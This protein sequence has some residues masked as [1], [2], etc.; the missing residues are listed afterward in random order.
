MKLLLALT[1]VLLGLGSFAQNYNASWKKV[2]DL[3][4][5]GL[6]KSALAE[7]RKIYDQAKAGKND[8]Q[9]VKALVY[10]S[11]LQEDNRE[12]NLEFSTQELEKEIA[13]SKEPV[14][15]VL[16]SLLAGYYLRYYNQNRWKLFN[17][18]A[19]VNFIK[20]D[21]STWSAED[22]HKKISELFLLSVENDKILKQTRIENFDP[23]IIKGNVRH[24]R[25]TLYDLLVH[26]AIGYFENDERDIK[27]PAYAFQLDNANAFDPA[28]EF[29]K[30]R[31]ASR[32]SLALQLKALQLYQNLLEFHL[33]DANPSALI[34][35]DINRLDFV[36]RN[37]VH[38]YKDSLYYQSLE[39]ITQKY[40]D[41]PAAAMAW[42]LM[43]AYLE[44]KASAYR[45]YSDST[46][47][48]SRVKA[49]T[50]V[51][52]ILKQKDSSEGRTLAANLLN[53]INRKDLRFSIEKVNLPGQPLRSL[54]KYRNLNNVHLRIVRATDALKKE[55]EVQRMEE[56]WKLAIAASPLKS[57]QQ[58]LPDPQDMQEHGAE[59]KID[60]LDK[61]EYILLA[62]AEKDF[63]KKNSLVGARMFYVSTIS[64]VNSGGDYFV[65]NRDNGQPLANAAIQVW[66]QKYDYSSYRYVKQKEKLYNANDKGYF[67]LENKRDRGVNGLLL[68][69]T[70]NNERFFLD[71]IIYAPYY[72][73]GDETPKE[74][75]S[76]HLFTD[77]SLYR[78][79]QTLYFKG[80]V[81]KKDKNG[82]SGSVAAGYNTTVYLKNANHQDVDSV[83]LTTNEFGSFSASF[84]L[85]AS[86]LNGQFSLTTKKDVSSVQ[87]RV[88]E[89]K[90]PKFYVEFEPVKGSYKV[91]DQ[92]NVTGIAKAYAGNSTDGASVSYRVVRQPRFL[93][94]WM[95]WR[96]WLPPV[97]AMEI[98]HG[99]TTTDKDGRFKVSFT[100]I[101]DLKVDRKFEPVFDYV[102][103][104][105]ITDI[106]G[107]TRS[108][109]NTIT[110]GYKSLLLKV[111]LPETI[112]ADSLNSILIRTENMNG[113]FEPSIVRVR[114]NRLK[115]E[116][117]LIRPRYWERPDQFILSKEEYIRNFPNDEYD[118]ESDYRGWDKMEIVYDR[119][120]SVREN[121]KWKIEN[122][123]LDE[124]FYAIEFITKDKDGNEV[125]DTRYV[126]VFDEKSNKI[127]T[128]RY[129]WSQG[130]RTI[131]PG[132]KTIVRLGSAASD[133]FVIREISRT[134]AIN[135][136]NVSEFDFFSINNEK[137][138]FEFTATEA[139][140]GGYGVNWIFVKHNRFYQ[141][142]QIINVPW[143]NKQLT[144]EYAS[145][146]DKTLPG[147]AETWKLKISGYKN[148]KVAAEIL[149]G[150]YDASLDQF[151]PHSWA[152]PGLWPTYIS[153]K[154][155]TGNQNFQAVESY[156]WHYYEEIYK[157][158]DKRYD[159]F[160]FE[161]GGRYY[162][163]AAPPMVRRE[164][165]IQ[166]V[167]VTAAK[168]MEGDMAGQARKMDSAEVGN[169]AGDQ[170]K[171]EQ[172]KNPQQGGE[173]QIRKNFNE[174]AFFFPQLRTS[175]DGSIEFSFTLPE[176]L[177]RW[178]FMSVAHT[179][180]L[181]FGSTVKEIV[182]QK[183][184]MV[185]PNA[186]RFLREGDKMEFSAKLSNLTDKEMT[187]QAEL[188]LFDA[189][190]N[191]PVDG[192]FNNSFPVQYFT[193]A[194]GESEAIKFPIQVPYQFDRALV[195]RI[196]ARSGNYSDGE[197]NALPV[198]TN[199]M[200]V[201]ETITLPVRG[202]GTK[203]FSFDKLKSVTS[204][205]LKNHSLTI[206]YTSNPAWYAVQ[207]LPYLM[208]FPYDCAE[209]NWNRYYA[210]SLAAF[211]ANSS[212]RIK[213]VF[214][215]WKTKD[216]AALLS[217]LQKNQELKS[218]LLEETPWVL[219]AKNETEQKKNIALLFDMIKMSKE[220]SS[221]FEKL[222]QMQ[223]PNG[224]FVW[225]K[226]GP[227]D[228]Y[229][230][231]YIVSG[232]GHLRKLRA[233]AQGQ[234]NNLASVLSS[235]IPYLDKKIKDDYDLLVKH[236][237][238]LK[239][240]VP[241]YIEIQYLY[242]RSFFPE[243]QIAKASQTAY[244][245]FR[246]RAMKTWTQ[247]SKYM[248]GMTALTA[249][250]KNDPKTAA[251]IL[252]SLKETA[253]VNE[254][255][256]MYWLHPKGWFWFQ[257][258]IETQALMIEVFQEA[259]KD[260]NT[261]DDLRTWLLKNKQTT[262]WRTTKATAEAC[263]ALLLQGTS[264]LQN[265]PVVEI[266]L[267]SM[268]V[269][270]TD[271]PREA[272]TGYFKKVIGGEQVQ[273]SM[274]N[275]S[276]TISQ[277]V[278][279]STN[280]PVNQ[281]ITWGA[282]YWQYFEDL[283]KITNAGTPLKLEKK[284]FIE[285]NT[286]RG[287][288]LNPVKDGD[289]LKVGDKIKVRVVL[290]VDRDMEY[291]HMKDMRA[292]AL[293]PVNV[294]SNYKWQGGLGYYETTRDASTNFFFNYL[295]KGTYVF[296]YPLFVTHKGNFSNGI[297]SIQS[298]Y[299]PEFSAHS[300]GI[301]IN[302]E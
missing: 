228:R 2:E 220:L 47:R 177:T 216:T 22:F 164:G 41:L 161:E 142:S 200:L 57:W 224:G 266:K 109:E 265:E 210:N 14:T 64:F 232:I 82:K 15:S 254:E 155:W 135:R 19:T 25:P 213:Q 97:E 293:E 233:V 197:E 43:A 281:P 162:D 193:V 294:L 176:A 110:A 183:Q 145:F 290:S 95:F 263:Y 40:G 204:E 249:F 79:G 113:A 139:D 235:A 209:Q 112:S 244:N 134:N 273:P 298:M 78:P 16:N 208:E 238:D 63:N 153:Y 195:W 10:L 31:F 121:G 5:K 123:K 277:P 230:T 53:N 248:Q 226:G 42:Y 168:G 152:S 247:Q 229:M 296:E 35:A 292:S 280:Q 30:R 267:G 103:Y 268:L 276:V 222:K 288:V 225:F 138:A 60:G 278:N 46:H 297:T 211:I 128:V 108:A 105:D 175:A 205:T 21:I 69:I 70:Y 65:L 191:S 6:P 167:R 34:D 48:L 188:H 173:V 91:N 28:A 23:V 32:D 68:D 257:A 50:I 261:V 27:R 258:P 286:D 184:L 73:R 192:W 133:L 9:L 119:S 100:A 137:K 239:K 223:S 219:Q 158:L 240:Y 54:I 33:G 180:D 11:N 166:E 259:G 295:R 24:L 140:R 88:E 62:G 131:E 179:K 96:W 157:A 13:N 12:D 44:N 287:P 264:W 125:K 1:F 59:I 83:K 149:A 126:E 172:Q 101:P 55:L 104:A 102:V 196:V 242:M 61:G 99:E 129:A 283:D 227:D 76:V 269:R 106:N 18:T 118:N 26:R 136:E 187:G 253:I 262:N 98:A 51:E 160:I 250:R 163:F 111:E 39:K 186:P 203:N 189:T 279:Q 127:N 52:R 236:K 84:Q 271:N 282:V 301:R 275:I 302:V 37:S 45:P 141:V 85:P 89:Y 49:K 17:R 207:A 120:D 201:T 159:R 255:L 92:V 241:G 75:T 221:S 291:V 4:N 182:T 169:A 114:I 272:G 198:L 212:P 256:G 178:K 148:E 185:Q 7:V 90:R 8:G 194:A 116:T 147:S 231:Q 130:G 36:Y 171:E 58:S 199:R 3:L 122:K 93:Y 300:E 289:Y 115:P 181:S 132:E 218:I 77:R 72:Y 170:K 67:R 87:F 80:I 156:G 143:T 165:L 29:I 270:S 144:I 284:L 124:G 154:S 202:T 86:G 146:R 117:R 174:T 94:P 243:M 38:P 260:M 217:N 214:E 245:Y 246:D 20:S 285:K 206:E 107:E 150:M 151:Y 190:T 74:I 237:T 234:D 252:K 56:F 274:G 251:A 299:A 66:E 71:E 81:L 215:Q